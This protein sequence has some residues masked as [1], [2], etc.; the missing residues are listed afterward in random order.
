[1]SIDTER[2][3]TGRAEDVH[4]TLFGTDSG[5]RLLL[6]HPN[7]PIDTRAAITSA[8]ES[9]RVS[10]GTAPGGLEVSTEAISVAAGVLSRVN[11][12][13]GDVLLGTT[14]TDV[15]VAAWSMTGHPLLV[16][17]AASS[18][19][20]KAALAA[21][22]ARMT[23]TQLHL[24]S[25]QQ[26]YE[27]V[28]ASVG[29]LFGPGILTMP[30]WNLTGSSMSG[31]RTTLDEFTDAVQRADISTPAEFATRVRVTS[32]GVVVAGGGA[33]GT[34]AVIR[35][36]G[37]D[38]VLDSSLRTPLPSV[39]LRHSRAHRDL[40]G[41]PGDE[42][43]LGQYA[44]VWA[45][46]LLTGVGETEAH[47]GPEE[48]AVQAEL[49]ASWPVVRAAV[50]GLS[51]RSGFEWLTAYSTGRSLSPA[52]RLLY[53]L[54]RGHAVR[55][56]AKETMTGITPRNASDHGMAGLAKRPL[57]AG[58]EFDGAV[59]VTVAG[60][61]GAL[62][63]AKNIVEDR[64]NST[65]MVQKST[66]SSG[67]AAFS[68]VL[69]GTEVWHDGQ[70]VHDIAGIVEGMKVQPH[71]SLD[72]LPPAQRAVLEA[73]KDAGIRPGDS[74]VL[75]G[76]SLGGIDAAGLASNRAFQERYSVDALTTFGA[77]VGGFEFSQ[78]TSVMAVEHS[79]DM[80]PPLDGVGNPDGENRSTVRVD[81]QYNGQYST[82][83]SLSGVGAHD[84][85]T[86][87]LGAQ[88]ISN[89]GHAA[90]TKHEQ[91]LRAAIPA[92]TDANTE[93]YIYEATEEHIVHNPEDR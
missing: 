58:V 75:T 45:D 80:V 17:A 92:G 74:V 41:Q 56:K 40:G 93:T 12:R 49:G 21:A 25:A 48:A 60:T 72:E 63:D 51:G 1:M 22:Q 14:A 36:V 65:V 84:M 86:Y 79:D 8:T 42:F 16:A 81:T 38:D 88:G 7:V 23:L 15:E 71:D 82:V 35:G 67:R 32:F 46:G 59:P 77:P 61:A 54:V 18:A 11:E 3:I 91:A 85:Y 2:V 19:L 78:D 37:L 73:L 50:N 39:V 55:P 27:M 64:E 6:D 26:H 66:D 28:E 33:E 62:K 52:E 31:L 68:V 69:T 43:T 70:G 87:T 83:G 44:R 53:P 20:T 4:A 89:S 13:A 9:M 5:G 10:G 30:G 57:P 24:A 76:H 34:N 90:V 29:S 47:V